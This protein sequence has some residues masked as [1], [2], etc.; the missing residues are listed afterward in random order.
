MPNCPSYS[1]PD[2]TN[3]EISSSDPYTPSITGYFQLTFNGSCPGIKLPGPLKTEPASIPKE[4]TIGVWSYCTNAK[5]SILLSAFGAISI[6][7]HTNSSLEA[8]IQSSFPATISNAAS[9]IETNKWIY[10]HFF[11]VAGSPDSAKLYILKSGAAAPILIGA[12]N[13]VA[14]TTLKNYFYLGSEYNATGDPIAS[15]SYSG[16]IFEL[17]YIEKSITESHILSESTRAYYAYSENNAYLMAYWH[18]DYI[19]IKG[20]QTYIKDSSINQLNAT[21]LYPT[22]SYPQMAQVSGAH[23]I[24][25]AYTSDVA[26]CVDV[27]A[28][29][30]R[31]SYVMAIHNLVS[32]R[33]QYRMNEGVDPILG[34]GKAIMLG[35]YIEI[36]EYN[37][38][39]PTLVKTKVVSVDPEFILE[40]IDMSLSLSKYLGKYIAVCY[41]FKGA[42]YMIDKFY[43]RIQ[44]TQHYHL[45]ILKEG[46]IPQ[47]SIGRLAHLH[48]LLREESNLLSITQVYSALTLR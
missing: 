13:Y 31:V 48:L 20:T 11:T 30:S 16:Y 43:L 18:L 2:Y 46:L 29:S 8:K 39:S 14:P 7:M 24:K 34:L 40:D 27:F 41:N 10:Y 1:L 44:I 25:M 17:K 15:S 21:I 23:P 35:T 28:S 37:C 36:K 26:Q 12:A 4:L 5:D 42:Y 19:Y 32:N 45:T 47:Y 3:L 6:L 38:T 22:T 9:L 33:L